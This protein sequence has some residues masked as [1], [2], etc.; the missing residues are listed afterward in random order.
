MET[1]EDSRWARL[2]E[3]INTEL[4]PEQR[5]ELSELIQTHIDNTQARSESMMNSKKTFIRTA[6]SPI[7]QT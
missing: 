2:A 4:T 6:V 1:T 3:E 7:G 5:Q